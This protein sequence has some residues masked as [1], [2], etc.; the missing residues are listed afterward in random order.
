MIR[1]TKQYKLVEVV[2]ATHVKEFLHLPVLLYKSDPMWVQ[3]ID[4][5]INDIFNPAKNKHFRNGEACRWLAVDEEGSTVGRV[6]AFYDKRIAANNKQKTGGMGFF[7]SINDRDVAFLLFDRCKSWLME[8]GMEAMDGPVNFGDRDR[9]WG[10]LVE[11]FTAPNYRMPYNFKYY[12]SFFEE[13]GFRNYFDQYTYHRMIDPG[14]IEKSIK[15]KAERIAENPDYTF[16]HVTRKDMDNLPSWFLTIYN[17][18]WARFPGVK[19][20]TITH[21]NAIFKS[22]KPILD[23][24]LL[25]F[26]FYKD[27]PVSFFIMLPEINPIIKLLNGR[28]D[29]LGKLKFMWYRHLA[30]KCT[31]AF[32]LIFGVVPEHQKRG[33]EGAIIMAF[34][35]VAYKP[36]FPYK[37]LEFNWIGDFNPSMMHLLEQIGARI[38]KTHYTYRLLFD[39]E[40]KFERAARVNV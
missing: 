26:G 11:G 13:Y 35:K 14:G 37:D 18:A 20:I 4:E 9:W 25:W 12:R 29:L 21:A 15:D 36:G 31:R 2:N 34:S 5:D 27:E 10:L 24:K 8:R 23:R 19:P 17:K 3:P 28:M 39:P 38:V 1:K 6:A 32:G 33:V 40:A 7:E 16:K 22:I 30:G